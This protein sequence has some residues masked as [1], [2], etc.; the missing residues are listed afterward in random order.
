VT[1][2]PGFGPKFAPP[3]PTSL[4][5]KW[6]VA[7]R[8]PDGGYLEWT[9]TLNKDG[10][11]AS[12]VKETPRTARGNEVMA[13]KQ[14]YGGTYKVGMQSMVFTPKDEDDQVCEYRLQEE[15]LTVTMS[16]PMYGKVRL[17]FIRLPE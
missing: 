15:R 9:L 3:K 8:L 1:L 17:D 10:T 5:G 11:Y 12:L 4:T 7:G 6:H 16:H 13:S 14:E 2:P